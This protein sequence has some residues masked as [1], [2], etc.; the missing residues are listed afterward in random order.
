MARL[1]EEVPGLL[2]VVPSSGFSTISVTVEAILFPIPVLE[3]EL[4]EPVPGIQS[5]SLLGCRQINR[6]PCL[7]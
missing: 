2:T 7:F 1:E 4:F 6:K 5:S 3:A